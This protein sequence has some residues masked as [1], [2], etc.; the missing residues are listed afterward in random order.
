[1]RAME[2]L[3]FQAAHLDGVLRLCTAE[4]W[5]SLPSSPD[6]ALRVLTCSGGRTVV[7]LERDMVVGFCQVLSDGELQ[8][9]CSLLLVGAG[10][11][12]QG[13]GRALLLTA[14]DRAGG[15]RM[16]LLAESTALDFYRSLRHREWAGFRIYPEP[17]GGE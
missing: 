13:V 15:Q 9:F 7:A 4:G 2:L 12:R 16:D 17:A 8:A 5:P 10:A 3:D 11:R 14:L 6:R 1:M